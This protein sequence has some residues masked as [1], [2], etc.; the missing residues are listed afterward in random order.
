MITNLIYR[1]FG[2]FNYGGWSNVDLRENLIKKNIKLMEEYRKKKYVYLKSFK[3]NKKIEFNILK[4]LK[5][6]KK[7]IKT[8]KIIIKKK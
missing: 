5:I 6:K 7:K 8:K 2:I 3:N 4:E 1:K